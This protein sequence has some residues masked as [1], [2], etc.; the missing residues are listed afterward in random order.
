M[1][2]LLLQ[3]KS[4]LRVIVRRGRIGLYSRE[5]FNTP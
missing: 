5:L 4:S 2:R 3:V 1:K